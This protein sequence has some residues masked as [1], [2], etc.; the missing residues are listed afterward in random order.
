[1]NF[2]TATLTVTELEQLLTAADPGV[3]LAPG[4]I[5]RRVIKKHGRVA[6]LGLQVPHRKSYVLSRE[7]LYDVVGRD[8]LD[9][10]PG[11]RLPDVVVLLPRPE[12][13]LLSW[14]RGTLLRE[15]WRLLFH[16][17]VHAA[18]Q[19]RQ[20][21]GALGAAAVRDRVRRLGFAEFAEAGA[22][23]RQE[24][25]LLPPGDARGVYEEFAAV[26]LELRHF[27]P[28]QLPLYFPACADFASVDATLALDVDGA[29]LF[30]ATR[31]E[32]APDPAPAAP[33]SSDGERGASAPCCGKNQGWTLP[34][35]S[36]NEEF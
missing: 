28:H 12:G 8:E 13:K 33:I 19:L 2:T 17:R 10:A 3:V 1:M 20:R 15:Y 31:L 36:D 35:R 24:H 26:Y 18:L 6:G 21:S 7:E 32:G 23:L 14:S 16:A 22:V 5:L 4:R 27:A 11:R 29:A 25:F 9:L 34:A 30:A